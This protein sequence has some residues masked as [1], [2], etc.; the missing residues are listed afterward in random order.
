MDTKNE[1]EQTVEVRFLN[2]MCSL[3]YESTGY[4]PEAEPEL[5]QSASVDSDP[6]KLY[7]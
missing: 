6:E 5:C 1:T 7:E 3:Y 4:A 2:R